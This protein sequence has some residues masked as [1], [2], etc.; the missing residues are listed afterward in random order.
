MAAS[1]DQA[2]EMAQVK[3]VFTTT[4]ENIQLPESKRQLIVPADIRR[5]GLSRILNS[6][7]MLATERPIPLDF[8][9][10][11]A[12]LRSTL[13]DYLRDSGLS[14]ETTVTLQY[15]RSLIPPAFEAS[16]QH[17][18]WVS[19]VDVAPGRLLSGS[20]DGLLRLWNTSGHV[21]AVSPDAAH[22]GHTAG[23]KA[24]RFV[25]SSQIAS[26][27][28]DRTVRIWK[29]PVLE[30]DAVDAM[31]TDTETI[32]LLRPTLELYGHKASVDA[33]ATD[34]TARRVLTAS[35][36][37]Q[38]GVWTTSK[39]SAPA[40]PES[41]LPGAAAA[42][43]K[44]RKVASSA[45]DVPRRGPLALI[46]AHKGQPA[47]A[48]AFDPRDRTVAYSA[49]Q[50]GAVATLDLTTGQVVA[51][52]ATSHALLSLCAV[53]SS[54]ASGIATTTSS[55]SPLLAVGNAARNIV[56]VDPRESVATTAV[57]TLRGH[58]NKVVAL[59]AAPDNSYSLVSA[60]HDG[61][62]RIWDLR[63]SRR[64]LQDGDDD[65]Q[66]PGL[67][68]GPAVSEAVYVIDREGREGK[69]RPL[70]GEGVKVFDLVWDKTWGIVSG[71]EDK[72]VQINR[73]RDIVAQEA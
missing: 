30:N 61:T 10:D 34:S 2:P 52:V 73:G 32:Q 58:V 22:G 59:A 17:D 12:F 71:G 68:A 36:D 20:Y 64:G 13:A 70:A 23:I 4:D 62:C 18:D 11:G 33:V 66:Q 63:S 6:E 53:G 69:A 38:I 24:A 55:S 49:G 31:D 50:D 25:T 56:L 8:L 60:S 65:S 16:F 28:I 44:R 14:G 51:T 48:V 45:P 42:A 40:A 46:A 29:A 72:R 21:T 15:V 1:L 37:G 47:T 5:Y 19:A 27:G 35:A 9:V 41:L 57:M 54:S 67:G 7:S 3:V 39:A 43:A 26:A